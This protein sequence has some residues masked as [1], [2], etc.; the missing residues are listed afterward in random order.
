MTLQTN[1]KYDENK[2][3]LESDTNEISIIGCTSDDRF[4]VNIFTNVDCVKNLHKNEILRFYEYIDSVLSDNFE[5][6]NRDSWFVV[7]FEE[8]SK[9][10]RL[11]DSLN[12]IYN[13]DV[14]K[15]PFI[16]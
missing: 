1:F 11:I 8:L 14:L 16:C 9:F 10:V 3:F 5:K 15:T 2:G 6:A 13:R 7:P 4:I 12:K